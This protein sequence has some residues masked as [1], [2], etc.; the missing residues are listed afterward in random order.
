MPPQAVTTSDLGYSTFEDKLAI[1]SVLFVD[2]D[3]HKELPLAIDPIGSQQ[4]LA[5][6]EASQLFLMSHTDASLSLNSDTS[7]H[8]ARNN[9]HKQAILKY[10]TIRIVLSDR[11]AGRNCNRLDQLAA[12]VKAIEDLNYC[13]SKSCSLSNREPEI[14][15]SVW[16]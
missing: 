12:R 16:A 9:I 5:S 10:D 8:S 7:P 14:P 4:G 2:L 3:M 13:A 15:V 6:T 11:S 1:D